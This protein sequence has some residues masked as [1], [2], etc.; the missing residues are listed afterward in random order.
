MLPPF[1]VLWQNT[2]SMLSK[3]LTRASVPRP[4][5]RVQPSRPTIWTAPA[6]RN[7]TALSG[8]SALA[9]LAAF[10]WAPQFTLDEPVTGSRL[11]RFRTPNSKLKSQN[12][13]MSSAKKIGKFCLVSRPITVFPRS[14]TLRGISPSTL[15][16]S[17]LTTNP[18]S[19]PLIRAVLPYSLESLLLTKNMPNLPKNA[20]ECQKKYLSSLFRRAFRATLQQFCP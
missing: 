2:F 9:H 11:L 8:R 14:S 5:L 18:R 20:K 10:A 12:W 4:E 1:S 16:D 19:L 6:E 13:H 7:E 15:P 3:M 17:P